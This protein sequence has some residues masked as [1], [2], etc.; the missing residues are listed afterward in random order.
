[1]SSSITTPPT[2]IPTSWHGS[3]STD[4]LSSTSP[5]HPRPGST[6]SSASLPNSQRS[7]SSTVYSDQCGNSNTPS[8]ASSTT[9]TKIQSPLPGPRTQTK[10]S[11]LSNADTKC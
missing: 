10:S 5:R 2:N 8:T 7:V 4:G 11:P 9:P 1:M 3:K 6:L